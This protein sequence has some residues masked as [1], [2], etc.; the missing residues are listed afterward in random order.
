[1]KYS[2]KDIQINDSFYGYFLRHNQ[3]DG[4]DDKD[5]YDNFEFLTK[6]VNYSKNP[7]ANKSVLDVGSGTGDLSSFL[8]KRGVIDYTGIELYTM[9]AEYARMKY[10]EDTFITGDFLTYNFQRTFDY[11]VFSGALAA[12][13][14]TDN[15][16]M[17]RAFIK[18]MWDLATIGIAFNFITRETHQEKDEEL[19]LYDLDEVLRICKEVAPDSTVNYLQNHAGENQEF[20]QTHIYLVKG[21][22]P[23][24]Q[25]SAG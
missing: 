6:I 22:L 12:V 2:P 7:L 15:Y 11:V 20:L 5:K 23:A 16:K 24:N 18:K 17:M 9:S 8:N 10:P 1:M 19:F 4:W 3:D 25:P 14:E 21:C 13:L